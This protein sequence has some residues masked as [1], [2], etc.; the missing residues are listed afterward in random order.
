MTLTLYVPHPERW[1][2]ARR[3]DMPWLT[4]PHEDDRRVRHQ[5]RDERAWPAITAIVQ[6]VGQALAQGGYLV[7]EE[8]P[9]VAVVS[10]D[11]PVMA[12]EDV[13]IIKS[14]FRAGAEAP[15]A[16]PWD[17]TLTNG[18]HRLWAAWR[19][20]PDALLPVH[21]DLIAYVD[22][23]PFMGPDFAATISQSALDGLRQMPAAPAAS[24]PRYI[25]ELR[26]VAREGGHDVDGL[27]RAAEQTRR[28]LW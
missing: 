3:A 10:A 9:T 16:E 8:D 5:D 4:D 13:R 27:P 2:F 1:W 22:D 18:R 17:D 24:S 26:R 25:E 6:A 28:H 23:M 7:H 12:A 14:W 20:V 15:A 19:A 21:S 11:A